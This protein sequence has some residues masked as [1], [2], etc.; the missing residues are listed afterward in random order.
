MKKVEVINEFSISKDPELYIDRI[1]ASYVSKYVK[2][3]SVKLFEIALNIYKKIA[4]VFG[5]SYNYPK[6]ELSKINYNLI[7]RYIVVN[8]EDE[9][10]TAQK[11]LKRI[12]YFSDDFPYKLKK[13]EKILQSQNIYVFGYDIYYRLTFYLRPNHL[14]SF[15][16][17]NIEKMDYIIFIFFIMEFF[18]PTLTDKYRFS[19]QVNMIIDFNNQEVDTEFIKLIMYYFSLYYPLLINKINVINF[20]LANIETNF[21]FREELETLNKFNQI[22]FWSDSYKYHLIKEYNPNVLPKQYG[23]Y[24]LEEVKILKEPKFEEFIEYILGLIMIKPI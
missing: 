16:N 23:G 13:L 12:N 15:K 14:N 7:A 1:E 8:E 3:S 22:D 9:N 10:K 20:N 21:S 19:D 5:N 2:L 6:Q 11:I 18:L 4:T 17:Q 24:H